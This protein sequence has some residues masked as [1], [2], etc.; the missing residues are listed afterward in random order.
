MNDPSIPNDK[1]ANMIRVYQNN[2]DDAEQIAQH[3]YNMRAQTPVDNS[4]QSPRFNIDHTPTTG[5]LDSNLQL[6]GNT[7]K[8]I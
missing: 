5:I 3:V 1:K 4:F 2:P 8:E 6:A 7:W